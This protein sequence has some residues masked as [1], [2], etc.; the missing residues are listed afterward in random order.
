MKK[1]SNGKHMMT[2]SLVG[3]QPRASYPQ[4]H[5][6]AISPLHRRYKANRCTVC[7]GVSSVD[8]L[9]CGFSFSFF[10]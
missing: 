6:E 2:V 7:K 4:Q 8:R 3:K 5:V 10:W 1:D 9:Q